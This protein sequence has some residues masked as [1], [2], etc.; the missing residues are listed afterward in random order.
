MSITGVKSSVFDVPACNI[1]RPN[2]LNNLFCYE[3]DI[4]DHIDKASIEKELDSG[5]YFFMDYNEDR[6]VLNK[7][8]PKCKGNKYSA[9]EENLGA[10][11]N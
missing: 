2:I 3:V 10:K 6:Q 11:I 8:S 9:L 7:T 5:F 4:N 1:F